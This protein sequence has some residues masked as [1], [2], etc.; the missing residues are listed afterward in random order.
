MRYR[1]MLL[2]AG[3]VLLIGCARH[4]IVVPNAQSPPVQRPEVARLRAG[5]GRVD[6][7]PPPGAGLMGYGPEGARSR[8]Y[9]MRLYARALLLE[10]PAGER[11]ALVVTDLMSISAL[12]QRKAA[13]LLARDGIIGTD[14]LIVSATHTHSAPGHYFAV[15]AYDEQSSEVAGFDPVWTDTVA[16]R[17][18]RAVREAHGRLAPARAAWGRTLIWGQ[19]RV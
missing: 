17:I 14:R 18:A 3:A 12:V 13:E 4:P 10:D 6:L 15:P 5:F 19:T 11:I 2:I 1:S 9:R 16:S 7:T 8:G